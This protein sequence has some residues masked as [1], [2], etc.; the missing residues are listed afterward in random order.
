[1]VALWRVGA[2]SALLALGSSGMEDGA[3]LLQTAAGSTAGLTTLGDAM[4]DVMQSTLSAHVMSALQLQADRVAA[5][6]PDGP[7]G[8]RFLRQATEV[9]PES[10]L[11]LQIRYNTKTYADDDESTM[12]CLEKDAYGDNRC[13]MP[14]G[15]GVHMKVSAKIGRPIEE[16]STIIF[17]IPKPTIAKGNMVA[18]FASKVEAAHIECPACTPTEACNITY[19]GHKVTLKMPPCPIPAGEKVFVDKDFPIPSVPMLSK[20]EASCLMNMTLKREDGSQLAH[21]SMKMGMGS[22]TPPSAQATPA[23]EVEPAPAA[24]EHEHKGHKHHHR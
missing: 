3:V 4:A 11:T 15:N 23:A 12:A 22:L 14:F 8:V 2:C 20:V 21:L 6:K 7:R 17:D 10:N 5:G 24:A 19:M 1:M 18:M 9:E 16:G 13:R